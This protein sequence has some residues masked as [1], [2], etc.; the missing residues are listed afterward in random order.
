MDLEG[1]VVRVATERQ[2]LNQRNAYLE[3][4][5]RQLEAENEALRLR[6]EAVGQPVERSLESSYK[7][8]LDDA[9]YYGDDGDE[10]DGILNYDVNMMEGDYVSDTDSGCCDSGLSL[11]GGSPTR[12]VASPLGGGVSGSRGNSSSAQSHVSLSPSPSSSSHSSTMDDSFESAVLI[13]E[14]QQKDQVLSSV[15]G[16]QSSRRS[17]GESEQRRGSLS[18]PRRPSQRQSPLVVVVSP[19]EC[20]SATLKN[21]S[22]NQAQSRSSVITSASSQRTTSSH[23]SNS[24]Y[25]EPEH[26]PLNLTKSSQRPRNLTTTS[27]MTSSLEACSSSTRTPKQPSTTR[28]R[29]MNFL[30]LLFSLVV[31]QTSNKN[32]EME[33]SEMSE[34]EEQLEW[35]MSSVG[36][37]NSSE[38]EDLIPPLPLHSPLS[39]SLPQSISMHQ[40]SCML[41]LLRKRVRLRP[42]PTEICR[43]TS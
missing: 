42:R 36:A 7:Q 38:Q 33:E 39:N 21:S 9:D 40:W 27:M 41:D 35:M 11:A 15:V 22:S 23:L 34:L 3:K 17:N 26:L 24:A 20:H 14:P 19:E 31:N 1:E 2:N 43:K 37:S 28:Q 29:L 32:L 10:N 30:I 16:V 6:L 13:N 5:V 4:R 12:S 8:Y 25:R 18:C